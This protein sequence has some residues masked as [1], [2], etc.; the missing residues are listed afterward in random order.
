MP[1]RVAPAAMLSGEFLQQ[2]K[3][4]RDWGHRFLQLRRL[5][6]CS[7]GSG[8]GGR[9]WLQPECLPHSGGH[10]RVAE[11]RCKRTYRAPTRAMS[12]RYGL[13][14]E[15]AHSVERLGNDLLRASRQMKT[16]PDAVQRLTR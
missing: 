10:Y 16:S 7:F 1:K 2:A 13:Q 4:R 8:W 5:S 14:V 6:R 11:G 12:C 9:V 3:C 15:C